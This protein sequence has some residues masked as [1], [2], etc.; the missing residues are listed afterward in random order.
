MKEHGVLRDS[1]SNKEKENE[2]HSSINIF[3]KQ[4]VL[5][6]LKRKY[7]SGVLLIFYFYLCGNALAT[8][9]VSCLF[10]KEKKCQ[11]TR[12]CLD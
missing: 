8:S 11:L 1:L 4:H 2:I 9:F 12:G 3:S 7:K 10:M 5:G 6:S